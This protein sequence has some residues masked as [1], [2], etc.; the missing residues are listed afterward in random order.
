MSVECVFCPTIYS[1]I[2]FRTDNFFSYLCF[3][4]VMSSDRL[5]FSP[6][7]TS[8]VGIFYFSKQFLL[9]SIW[10]VFGSMIILFLSTQNMIFSL[11]ITSPRPFR[12][13]SY[14]QLD[15]FCIPDSV[16]SIPTDSLLFR[17]L[18][19]GLLLWLY[20]VLRRGLLSIPIDFVLFRALV[21]GL[22]RKLRFVLCRGFL[23]LPMNFLLFRALVPGLLQH[24]VLLC[25]AVTS[26]F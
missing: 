22:L 3:D 10:L 13:G 24:F 8:S 11:Q 9:S 19:P 23:C 5:D 26:V 4:D 2:H 25:A 12:T 17:A 21:P 7:V 16:L 1:F 18:V 15:F 14:E 20:F 6:E